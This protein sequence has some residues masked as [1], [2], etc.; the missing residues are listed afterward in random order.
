MDH[1]KEGV[2]NVDLTKIDVETDQVVGPV[3]HNPSQSGQMFTKRSFVWAF[4]RT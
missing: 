2:N 1:D 3:A 4:A